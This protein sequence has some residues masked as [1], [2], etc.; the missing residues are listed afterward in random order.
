MDENSGYTGESAKFLESI[1]ASVGDIVKSASITGTVMPRYE[2]GSEKVIVLKLANS[3]NVSVPLERLDGATSQPAPNKQE[4]EGSPA[5]KTD[6]SLPKVLL[7]STGGTIASKVDY[8][9][10][11]VTP[12]L[13][14]A[15]LAESVPELAQIAQID[16]EVVLSE[17]SENIEPSHWLELAQHIHG[18]ADKYAGIVVAHGTDTMQYTASFL[19]FALAGFP[20]P[21]VLVGSQ[22]SSDRPSSDA[23]E[24]LCAATMLAASSVCK[25]GVYVAMHTGVSDGEIS[26]HRGTRVRKCHTSER[27]AFESINEQPAFTLKDGIIRQND[28]RKY[29]ATEKY[30]PKISVNTNAALLKYYPGMSESVIDSLVGG[31][32]RAI[33]LEG[34]GLGHVGRS[35]YGAISRAIERNV[36]VAMCSQCIAGKTNMNVYESGRKLQAM[37]VVPLQDML[38]ETALAKAMW[39]LSCH[40]DATKARE[41]L[42]RSVASEMSQ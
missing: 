15:G 22:R 20:Q 31:G 21:I 10:G 42:L 30:E 9:T 40:D 3:Y 37:G 29:Y 17:H 26:Y 2:G 16:A 8:V 14:A 11:S 6:E 23:A 32:C 25:N 13:D 36:I 7:V 34:T 5:P 39:V 41:L 27:G 4:L 24:N 33:I 19:S 35:V 38:A 18:A 12:T 1:G 28:N